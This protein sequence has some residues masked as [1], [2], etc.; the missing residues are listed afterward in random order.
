M[1]IRW[2]VSVVVGT[3]TESAVFTASPALDSLASCE[4]ACVAVERLDSCDTG[5]QSIDVDR[6]MPLSFGSV[7]KLAIVILTPALNAAGR[8]QNSSVIVSGSDV[9]DF[10]IDARDISCLPKHTADV[11]ARLS[12]SG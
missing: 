3:V 2:D 4:R 12:V 6:R 7:T 1:D 10:C 9:S 5:R 8:C 11:N